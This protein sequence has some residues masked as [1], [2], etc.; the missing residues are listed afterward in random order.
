MPDFTS[1][2]T[3]SSSAGLVPTQPSPLK[4]R[5]SSRLSHTHPTLFPCPPVFSVNLFSLLKKREQRNRFYSPNP[6]EKEMK[7][8]P[9][10]SREHPRFSRSSQSQPEHKVDD[11]QFQHHPVWGR[12][13]SISQHHSNNITR[14]PMAKS[15]T[16]L[17]IIIPLALKSYRLSL[18]IIPTNHRLIWLSNGNPQ[19]HR[20]HLAFVRVTS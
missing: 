13:F 12:Y 1:S 14:H 10:P 15:L 11:V 18:K 20:C 8:V 9:A 3:A 2:A 17:C 19:I 7:A 6:Q 4:R 16:A 5:R